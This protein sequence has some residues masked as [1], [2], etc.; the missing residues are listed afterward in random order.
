MDFVIKC[1]ISAIGTCLL[2]QVQFV[3]NKSIQKPRDCEECKGPRRITKAATNEGTL[4]I[5][6]DIG[7]KTA[8]CHIFSS[9][10]E[11]E[12]RLVSQQGLQENVRCKMIGSLIMEFQNK[13]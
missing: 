4:Q 1:G 10:N 5:A 7:G 13:R 11:L 9:G 3:P 8:S 6:T 12:V 2:F